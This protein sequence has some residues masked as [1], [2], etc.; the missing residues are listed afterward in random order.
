MRRFFWFGI[1]LLTFALGVVFSVYHKAIVCCGMAVLHAR[2]DVLKIDLRAFRQGIKQYTS[3]KGVAPQS[4][5]DLVKAGYVHEISPDPITG[6]RNW[7]VI[8]APPEYPSK[9]PPGIVDVRSAAVG[10]SSDASL[11]SEW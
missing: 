2:E 4:L 11:Y 3:E 7:R 1:F 9:G 8:L 5:D 10:K 6:E